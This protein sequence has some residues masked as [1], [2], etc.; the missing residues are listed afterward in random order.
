[1][2]AILKI[3][4]FL[5]FSC[6][7]AQEHFKF[8][9]EIPDTSI[10]SAVSKN[11]NGTFS[12][13]FR[14]KGLTNFL[15][16]YTIYNFEIGFPGAR[17]PKLQTVYLIEC[18]NENL[19]NILVRDY[20]GYFP[21]S[22]KIHEAKF[23]YTPNDYMYAGDLYGAKNL[24]II[25][26]KEAWNY[27]KGDSGFLIGI[28]DSSIYKEHEDLAGKVAGSQYTY[29]GGDNHGTSSAGTASANT[30]NNLGIAGIGFNSSILGAGT[31]VS[32]LLWLSNHGAR[33]V[34]A[35]WYDY[36]NDDGNFDVGGYDQLAINEIHE[37]GTVI[38]V[39][40]GNGIGTGYGPGSTPCAN[41]NKFFFP[42]SYN[43]VIS[44]TSVGAQD[45]GYIY[46]PN[47]EQRGWRDYLV[48]PAN[49][50]NTHQINS[51]VDIAAI[52][53]GNWATVVPSAANNYAKYAS[54]GGT[55]SSAP[56][57]AG[58]ISLMLTANE[59]LS[60]EEVES[61]LKLTSS[62]LDTI[63]VNAPYHW[64]AGSGRMDIGKATKAAWQMNPANGGEV[65]LTNRTFSRWDFVL[66]NSPEYI[67]LK[68]ESFV[69]DAN[70]E[71]RAKKGITLD[72]NTLL[73]PGS[74]K[75]HYLYIENLNSCFN[76]NKSYNP[77]NINNKSGN[78]L[79]DK[80]KDKA[81]IKIYPNPS[82]D[83]I[84]ILSEE[85]VTKIEI[86][87]ISGKKIKSNYSGKKIEVQ[88]LPSG[89]Y[90]LKIYTHSQIS[91]LKFTK[92]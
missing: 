11:Q 28:S 79:N 43:H 72:Q 3:M 44:V 49:S 91:I 58:G 80:G 92:K 73:Q 83:F 31:S 33:V 2:K 22:E 7:Y 52:G 48:T 9:I 4:V 87:D 14:D 51:K 46:P 90:M 84:N 60:P 63:A 21:H 64:G 76:F 69:E 38:V 71:L 1:M 59:C 65:L 12:L 81:S 29:T 54:Y 6:F 37:N 13:S 32:S 74:G 17:T 47:G 27:S 50:T 68:N 19:R 55:S 30:D 61:L 34:N 89:S 16:N 62:R 40:A 57:V 70:V 39:A 78:I 86:F 45:I 36:C 15:R 67:R 85:A 41:P 56:Q 53:F 20:P 24:D 75:S 25:N 8:Y 5:S 66:K 18:N 77:D 26:V 10:L 35:S 88:N 23:L 42:A 82:K